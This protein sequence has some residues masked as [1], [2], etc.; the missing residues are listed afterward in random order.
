MIMKH[1]FTLFLKVVILFFGTGVLAA[2]IRLPQTEGR[3]ANYDYRS[4]VFICYLVYYQ[5]F[6]AD[7]VWQDK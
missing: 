3:A 6:A 2:M 5:F 7:A 4:T 1:S